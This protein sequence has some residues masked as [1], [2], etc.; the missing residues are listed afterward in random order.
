MAKGKNFKRKDGYRCES[1]YGFKFETVKTTDAV[2]KRMN[3]F[4]IRPKK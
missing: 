3:K 2:M 1:F 4:D